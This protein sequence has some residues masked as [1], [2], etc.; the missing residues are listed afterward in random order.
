MRPIWLWFALLL[1]VGVNLGVLATIGTDRLR[2][3]A[4]WDRGP[5]EEGP[6]PVERAADR[7]G[8]GGERRDAFIQIQTDFFHGMRESREELETLRRQLRRELMAENPDRAEVDGLID[9]MGQAYSRLD[10]VFVE[11]VLKSR[12]ILDPEQERRYLEFLDRLQQ[13]GRS[14]HR[15]PEGLPRKPRDRRP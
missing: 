2:E 1:S 15:R 3:P 7:L 12:E 10:R 6:P 13:R 11:N 14:G 8:L 5:T 4:R 9:E